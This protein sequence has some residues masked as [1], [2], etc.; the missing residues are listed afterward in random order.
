[1]NVTMKQL[2]DAGV[3][4]GHRRRR[5][6]PK[7]RPYIFTER[8]GIHII[9]LHQTVQALNNATENVRATV[10]NGGTVLFVGTKPQAQSIIEQE[11]MRCGMPYINQR[12]LGGTLTN[13]VTIRKRIQHLLQLERRMDAGEFRNLPKKERMNLQREVDK[14]NRRIGGLKN[15]R[16][17]PDMLFI[18]DT[19]KEN[20]AVREANRVNVPVVGMVDTNSNPDPVRYVIPTND[21]AIRSIK[22]IVGAMADAAEEGRRIREVEMAETGQV[23]REDLADMEQ[24]LGPSVLAKL[25]SLDEADFEAFEGEDEENID[26][27]H[28]FEEIDEGG[29]DVGLHVRESDG[30]YGGKRNGENGGGHEHDGPNYHGDMQ[31]PSDRY[32]DVKLPEHVRLSQVFAVRVAVTINPIS[33]F[34]ASSALPILFEKEAD[35]VVLDVLLSTEHIEILG[36]SIKE[37]VVPPYQ[38]SDPVVFKLRAKSAGVQ[39]V[40]IEFFQKERYIGGTEVSTIVFDEDGTKS[41][42]VDPLG[43][44]YALPPRISFSGTEA[45]DLQI[46]ISESG[47]PEQRM[48]YRFELHAPSLEIWHMPISE[49]LSFVG[50]PTQWIE[51]LYGELNRLSSEGAEDDL[52]IQLS[53]IGADLYERLIPQTLKDIWTTQIRGNVESIMI[54]SDEPWIPWELIKPS[55]QNDTGHFVEDGFLCDDYVVTRWRRGYT[56]ASQVAIL[57]GAVVADKIGLFH[58]EREANFLRDRC[59]FQMI[60]PTL[61]AVRSMLEIGGYHLLHFACHG[62]FDSNQHEQSSLSLE[63]GSLKVRDISGVRRNFGLSTPFVFINACSSSRTDFSLVGIGGWAERFISAN[64]SGFLG[65][66]WEVDDELAFEFARNFYEELRNGETIGKAAHLARKAIA[67]SNSTWLAYTLYADP[68]AIVTL[69]NC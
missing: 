22:L 67:K 51:G 68:N 34:S 56:P 45:A 27:D 7:M 24:Y 26:S 53:G 6:N 4:F 55:F 20:I 28:A 10:A 35:P 52:E 58:A 47:K 30:E 2:L 57:S 42:N 11:A 17:L 50:P 1:M 66:S 37:L 36:D 15:M 32:P 46:F 19:G 69:V 48:V 39:K 5:W 38:D 43:G 29:E 16:D 64:A 60:E 25:Q 21:D 44:D 63:D 3:H 41:T 9:D 59:R 23:S 33:S 18:V 62:R 61:A 54:V 12:W 65:T 13:W 14:L 49:E 40:R 31:P 8:S